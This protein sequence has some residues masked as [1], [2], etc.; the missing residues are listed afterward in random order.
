MLNGEFIHEQ[1]AALAQ[2]LQREHPDNL[3]QQLRR[4]V[5]LTTQRTPSADELRRDLAFVDE[6][7]TKDGLTPAAALEMYCLLTL[8]ANEFFYLD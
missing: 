1:S 7:R 8:N 2:R 4:A 5:E 3:E 6:A